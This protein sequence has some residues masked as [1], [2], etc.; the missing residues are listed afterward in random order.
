MK[1]CGQFLVIA[2]SCFL[3]A[4]GADLSSG[5]YSG[6][7]V[8]TANKV[9]YGT[10]INKRTVT[11]NNSSGVGGVAGAV[12]G[13]AVGS[14]IGGSFRANLLGG[15]GGVLAGALIGN[16]IDKSINTQQ[17]YEYIIRVSKGNPIAVT[18]SHENNLPVGMRVMVIYG[19][20]VRVVPA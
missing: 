13:G 16:A 19:D 3:A 1:R 18:Q 5:T 9:V 6:G 10:I 11:I 12:A 14:G 17:G 8:N 20:Q 4:C 7:Q 15:V 2:L